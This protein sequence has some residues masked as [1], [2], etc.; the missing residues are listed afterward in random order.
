MRA[1]EEY[2][3]I[4]HDMY[5]R[6]DNQYLNEYIKHSSALEITFLNGRVRFSLPFH[7]RFFV[8]FVFLSFIACVLYLYFLD[9]IVWI[10]GI[11]CPLGKPRD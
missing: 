1:V 3:V 11:L 4:I 2:E 6:V 7:V 10:K 5:V 8:V 9:I